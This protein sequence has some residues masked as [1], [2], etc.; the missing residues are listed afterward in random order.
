MRQIRHIR[1]VVGWAV[2]TL[3]SAASPAFAHDVPG[4]A[5][6]KKVVLDFYQALN[7][8]DAT[9]TTKER[10]QGIAEKFLSPDYVQH[11]EAFANL[12]GPGT[13]RD[14][15]IRMFQN[16]PPMK[17]SPA[18]KTL[19]VMAEGDLVMMLTARVAPDPATGGTKSIYI[20]NM[21][22]VRNNRLVEHWDVGP[23]SGPGPS[24]PPLGAEAP[25]VGM[26]PASLNNQ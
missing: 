10:I 17:A 2:A 12:P 5:A 25:P 6:N 21:F 16:M 23:P 14:K 15:L 19:A 9:G 26:P 18:P 22:R 3:L 11:S 20:F 4:E 7:T 1:K 13:A 8:A 24:M